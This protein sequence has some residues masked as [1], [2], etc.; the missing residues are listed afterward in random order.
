LRPLLTES[1]VPLDAEADPPG[2]HPLPPA[3][4]DQRALP[5][6]APPSNSWFRMHRVGVPVLAYDRSPRHRFNAP[7]GEFGILYCASDPQCAFIE[8]FGDTTWQHRTVSLA[9]LRLRSLTEVLIP[10][11]LRL[12]DLTGPRLAALGVDL[13]LTTGTHRIA[14]AWS[15]ALWAHPQQPDGIYYVSRRDSERRCIA[16]YDRAGAVLAIRNSIS[17]ADPSQISLL[18]DVLDTY[19]FGLE[20]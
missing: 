17:L 9:E 13:R 4:L 20:D 18:A 14:R 5:L 2:A 19:H 11:S 8:T 12:V 10:G 16:V 6:I 3:D 1:T 15:L 7:D